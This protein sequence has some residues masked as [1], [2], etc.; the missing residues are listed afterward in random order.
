M[1]DSDE[2]AAKGGGGEVGMGDL[3]QLVENIRQVDIET[4]PVGD[5]S[6]VQRTTIWPVVDAGQVYVR[7]LRGR[8]GRWFRAASG[9]PDVVLHVGAEAV[10]VRAIP[11][12]DPASVEHANA[13][14][15]RK[16][17]GSSALETMTREE[18]FPTTLR[19]DPR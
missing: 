10:P 2:V 9:S 4:H 17:A 18:I 1:N 11:A 16:Y 13:G 8:G 7:S 6:T 15:R 5:S 3:V 14:Y 12:P 19:L